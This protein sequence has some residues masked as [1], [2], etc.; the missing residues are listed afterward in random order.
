MWICEITIN[1]IGLIT[2]IYNLEKKS[3][4]QLE[5]IQF[6]IIL[7]EPNPFDNVLCKM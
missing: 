3:N 4:M 1:V 6:K 7:T 5:S 2:S